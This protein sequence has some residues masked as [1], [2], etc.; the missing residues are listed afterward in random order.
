MESQRK[1]KKCN[2]ICSPWLET[3]VFSSPS[4]YLTVITFCVVFSGL[5]GLALCLRTVNFSWLV[6]QLMSLTGVVS[7]P[8]FLSSSALVPPSFELSLEQIFCS[9]SLQIIST[10]PYGSGWGWLT[11]GW[12]GTCVVSTADERQFE[13]PVDDAKGALGSPDPTWWWTLQIGPVITGTSCPTG[14]QDPLWTGDTV[15]GDCCWMA[16]GMEKEAHPWG[17]DEVAALMALNWWNSPDE[18]PLLSTHFE[19]HWTEKDKKWELKTSREFKKRV[20]EC[21]KK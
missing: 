8:S 18:L 13:D 16:G 17:Q 9:W 10:G 15:T 11:W 5:V 4:R 6:S 1:E 12:L 2:Q 7:I 21:K 20:K 3:K 14:V 19:V